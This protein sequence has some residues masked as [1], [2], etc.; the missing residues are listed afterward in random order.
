MKEILFKDA[1]KASQNIITLIKKFGKGNKNGTS[2]A[3]RGAKT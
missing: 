1:H 3:L 2:F